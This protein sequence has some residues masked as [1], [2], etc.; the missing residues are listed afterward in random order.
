MKYF[1][2]ATRPVLSVLLLLWIAIPLMA[3][4]PG[5]VQ[6]IAVHFG[7]PEYSKALDQSQYPGISFYTATDEVYQYVEK[8]KLMGNPTNMPGWYGKLPETMGFGPNSTPDRKGIPHRRGTLL[9]VDATGTIYYQLPA[10]SQGGD[11]HFMGTKTAAKKVGKGKKAKA[12]KA[13]KCKTLKSTPV[14]QLQPTK[15]SKI[16]K[17]KTGLVGWKLPDYQLLDNDGQT[18]SLADITKGKSTVLVFYTMNGGHMKRGDTKGKIVK[19]WDEEPMTS[20]Q[21]GEDIEQAVTTGVMPKNAAGFL[22][23]TAAAGYVATQS[24][25]GHVKVTGIL[26]MARDIKEELKH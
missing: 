24:N 1:T 20:L 17:K 15:G 2:Q 4:S 11:S 13:K 16:D 21:T 8:Q 3:G 26:D 25:D 18:V 12:L 23:K 5:D 9:V 19:E 14:G 7:N 10:Y 22:L 6:Y